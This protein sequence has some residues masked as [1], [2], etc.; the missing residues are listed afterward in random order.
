MANRHRSDHRRPGTAGSKT[1]GIRR[2]RLEATNGSVTR[3]KR[4]S[5]RS[6]RRAAELEGAAGALA[7]RK[8]PPPQPTS[9]LYPRYRW[10]VAWIDANGAVDARKRKGVEKDSVARELPRRAG[11]C[12]GSQARVSVLNRANRHPGRRCRRAGRRRARRRPV[13]VRQSRARRPRAVR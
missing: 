13:R 10:R 2:T 12:N 11:C 9:R 8:R 7:T 5:K 4:R 6:R 1:N 3:R